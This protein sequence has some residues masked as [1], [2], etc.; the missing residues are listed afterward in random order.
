MQLVFLRHT[1]YLLCI[2]ANMPAQAQSL[3][4][5]SS[6]PADCA[7]SNEMLNDQDDLIIDEG[8]INASANYSQ[9]C[10]LN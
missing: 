8:T 5:G 7:A 9:G 1:E 3:W 2:A 10:V 4:L 6:S